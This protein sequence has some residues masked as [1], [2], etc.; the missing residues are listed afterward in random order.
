MCAAAP[1]HTIC[2]VWRTDNT[3]GAYRF[4]LVPVVVVVRGKNTYPLR[5]LRFSK[6]KA[7][8]KTPAAWGRVVMACSAG[9]VPVE[10]QA[11]RGDGV[12]ARGSLARQAGQNERAPRRQ[13]GSPLQRRGV[14]LVAG[15]QRSSVPC[16][17][18]PLLYKVW[19]TASSYKPFRGTT[20]EPTLA[21]TCWTRF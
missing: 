1:L 20:W 4:G 2:C 11:V 9:L 21:A 3:S 8:R 17:R 12:V 7:A 16:T 18:A 13:S 15:T 5:K 6:I 14:A 19:S 10:P